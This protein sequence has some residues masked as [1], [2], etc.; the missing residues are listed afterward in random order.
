[1]A[2]RFTQEGQQVKK[3]EQLVKTFS[4]IKEWKQKDVR[5]FVQE[6]ISIRTGEVTSE[7]QTS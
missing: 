6:Y 5:A 1:M 7:T 4:A 2:L 3:L